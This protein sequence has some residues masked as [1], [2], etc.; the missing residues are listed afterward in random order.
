[1]FSKPGGNNGILVRAK[2]GG[3]I[4]SDS[5]FFHHGAAM[6]LS[7]DVQVCDSLGSCVSKGVSS[8]PRSVVNDVFD[9]P[10][11]LRSSPLTPSMQYADQAIRIGSQTELC[12]LVISILEWKE[13]VACL[14]WKIELLFADRRPNGASM[15][16]AGRTIK[17]RRQLHHLSSLACDSSPS[18]HLSGDL[19][20]CASARVMDDVIEKV[21]S[22]LGP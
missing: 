6:A 4:G 7:W 1:M 16:A 3:L 11:S 22:A 2:P 13:L 5:A 17:D 14:F 10:L 19:W 18:L 12:R 9:S 8:K 15:L 20:P 21:L